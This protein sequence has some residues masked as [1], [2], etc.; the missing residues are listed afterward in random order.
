MYN[1]DY[2]DIYLEGYY[3]ALLEI[4]DGNFDDPTNLRFFGM[5]GGG[6]FGGDLAS[7][8]HIS[9]RDSMKIRAMQYAMERGETFKEPFLHGNGIYGFKDDKLIEKMV[10]FQGEELQIE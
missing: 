10:Y 5:I 1:E 8:L 6:D 3:D 7:A 9:D 4:K 2:E